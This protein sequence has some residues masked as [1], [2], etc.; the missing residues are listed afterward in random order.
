MIPIL[1]QLL[2]GF[3]ETVK[4]FFLTLAFSI[5]LGLVRLLSGQ[6]HPRNLRGW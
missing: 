4:V 5:P 6:N 2:E 3:Y 1:L